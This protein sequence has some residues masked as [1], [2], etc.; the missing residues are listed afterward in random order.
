MLACMDLTLFAIVAGTMNQTTW[1]MNKRPDLA[2]W[3]AW[4]NLSVKASKL[5]RNSIALPFWTAMRMCLTGTTD[6][7]KNPS[8][9]NWYVYIQF[10]SHF[11][12]K[13][14]TSSIIPESSLIVVP[15]HQLSLSM[16]TIRAVSHLHT[17]LLITCLPS[18]LTSS[19]IL[20]ANVWNEAKSNLN[21]FQRKIC[22][23]MFYKVGHSW[24]F[25]QI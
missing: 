2:L 19:T 21:M 23:P 8:H 16:L 22:W 4:S 12:I 18:I 20:F 25:C 17:I 10:S 13:S 5:S 11:W 9:M 3:R 7:V 1:T 6:S 14:T 15:R 24:V